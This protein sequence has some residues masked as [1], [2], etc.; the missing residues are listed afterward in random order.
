M[1]SGSGRE[2]GDPARW[3]RGAGE[4]DGDAG[5][6]GGERKGKREGEEGR[7]G[8]GDVAVGGTKGK[9]KEIRAQHR[10]MKRLVGLR[11]G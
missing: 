3:R 4:A 10:G 6:V 5:G 2:K 7:D 11:E 9:G 1:C 8:E